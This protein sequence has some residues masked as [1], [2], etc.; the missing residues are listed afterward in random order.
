[1]F[2]YVMGLKL[3]SIFTG[4]INSWNSGRPLNQNHVAVYH[5]VKKKFVLEKIDSI[6]Q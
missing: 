6:K 3:P 4:L 5:N 2:F 1:M